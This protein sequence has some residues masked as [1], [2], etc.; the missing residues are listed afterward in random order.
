MIDLFAHI[1]VILTCIKLYT[2]HSELGSKNGSKKA[3]TIAL[4]ASRG[5]S[6]FLFKLVFVLSLISPWVFYGFT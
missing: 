2:L 4:E 1:N 5:V 6:E 3:G